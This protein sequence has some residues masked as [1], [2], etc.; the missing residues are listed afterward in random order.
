[1]T[2]TKINGTK[3]KWEKG[4][5][6][7]DTALGLSPSTTKDHEDLAVVTEHADML[8]YS[9][10]SRPDDIDMLEDILAELPPGDRPLGLVAKIEQ[11][12]AL[13]NLPALIAVALRHHRSSG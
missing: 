13:S 7:P 6:L 10:L 12:E 3:L 8:G 1:M 9:F 11:P 2:R 5:N 4:L